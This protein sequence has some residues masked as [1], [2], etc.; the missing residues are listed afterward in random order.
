MKN[1][2]YLVSATLLAWLA[3]A[4]PALHAAAPGED[5]VVLTKPVDYLRLPTAKP[6]ASA[7][8][9]TVSDIPVD[10]KAK[11]VRY[12]AK[13]MVGGSGVST[14]QDVVTTTTSSAAGMSRTCVQDLASNSNASAFNR[15]GPQTKDQIVVLKGDLV[16]VCR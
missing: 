8:L 12:E 15:Y 16:N 6:A 9:D 13:A 1:A 4:A 2:A 14:D 3:A 5:P 11:I 7:G 10:V